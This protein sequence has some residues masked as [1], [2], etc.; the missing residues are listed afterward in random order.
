MLGE[1]LKQLRIARGYLLKD[2]AALLQVDIGYVSRIE[3]GGKPISK[4][5]LAKLAE[6]YAANE[7]ELHSLWLADKILNV[8][9][10]DRQAE[11]SIALA[12]KMI[13]VKA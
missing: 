12:Q 4:K 9:K 8:V 11:R 6:I 5:Q 2:V 1:S 3:T 10:D 13:K 7:E